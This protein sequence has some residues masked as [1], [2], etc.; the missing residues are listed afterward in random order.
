MTDYT[1]DEI[2]NQLLK[3]CL[4]ISMA[5]GGGNVSD[6]QGWSTN[7]KIKLPASRSLTFQTLW[8]WSPCGLWDTPVW[9]LV[10]DYGAKTFKLFFFLSFL[11]VMSSVSLWVGTQKA[12]ET[13]LCGFANLGKAPPPTPIPRLTHFPITSLHKSFQRGSALITGLQLGDL[14]LTDRQC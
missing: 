14:N 10:E 9:F 7:L 1:H 11:Q 5:G 2:T 12:Q 13:Q 8:M 3:L 4:R 6:G